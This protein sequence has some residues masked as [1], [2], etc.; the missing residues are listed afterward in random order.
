MGAREAKCPLCDYRK[1]RNVVSIFFFLPF[2]AIAAVTASPKAGY[3]L[4]I[5]AN[6]STA[7]RF[8]QTS[9]R[10]YA[11]T[12]LGR[13]IYHFVRSG[14]RLWSP[15]N[16]KMTGIV[17]NDLVIVRCPGFAGAD[18]KLVF[19][20]GILSRLSRKKVPESVSKEKDEKMVRLEPQEK[21][22][23]LRQWSSQKEKDRSLWGY[24]TF[25][26]GFNRLR[27]WFFN[28]NG[29]GTFFAEL[30]LLALFALMAIRKPS[31]RILFGVLLAVFLWCEIR[32]GSR[33]AF[34]GLLCSSALAALFAT[35]QRFSW[36]KL[37]IVGGIAV[38][39]VGLMW[40]GVFGTR[41]GQRILAMDWSNVERLRIWRE[42][43]RMLA[44][45]PGGWGINRSGAA[46][47]DW[48]QQMLTYHP[49][50]W[51]VNSHFTWIVELGCW[52]CA[53]YVFAWLSVLFVS[54]R[55]AWRGSSTGMLVAELA[56]LLFI[57]A[58]FSTVGA[59]VSLW[60]L[61]FLALS[62]FLAFEFRRFG[63]VEAILVGV[64]LVIAVITPVVLVQV[65]RRM[66]APGGDFL[67]V[68]RANGVTVVGEGSPTVYL[69]TDD[70]TLSVGGG[71]GRDLRRWVMRHPKAS[72]V[73]LADT[74]ERLPPEMDRLILAGY[75][76]VDY[77]NFRQRHLVDG[78]YPHA[79]KLVFLSPPFP[80][81]ILPKSFGDAGIVE[82]IYGEF[83]LRLDTGFK[84]LPPWVRVIKG[85]E[86]Y[87]PYWARHTG[88]GW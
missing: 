29:A 23:L 13:R 38:L 53:A 72:T 83:S 20:N 37:L 19:T 79:K 4:N 69:V 49:L 75:A 27:L 70:E 51:L 71:L 6:E 84:D 14:D 15:T 64:A 5:P 88:I 39:V 32:T 10:E 82:A 40:A 66:E 74:I 73:G 18:A 11:V 86:L 68:A 45:A 1:M 35:R 7:F 22:P 50:L 65:G 52:F 8:V 57:S 12:L 42:V 26:K 46:F 17:T 16:S 47:C 78:A 62:L 60:I 21:R 9:T 58:W 61:P 85:A 28:P 55:A 77:L 43:P 41:M 31:L 3:T 87:I 33:G 44:A 67:K 30:A 59:F 80:P 76:G 25:Q 54:F 63:R 81:S 2:M 56:V 34:L 48:F 36:K 24:W